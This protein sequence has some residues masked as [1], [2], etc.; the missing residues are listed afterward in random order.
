MNL[1]LVVVALVVGVIGAIAIGN[2]LVVL[3]AVLA[4]AILAN[5]A[6]RQPR[7]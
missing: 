6:G 3:V 1:F 5:R 4:G 2:V 7:R